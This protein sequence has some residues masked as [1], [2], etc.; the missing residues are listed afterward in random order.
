MDV[1]FILT[2]S[3]V[4]SILFLLKRKSRK[5]SPSVNSMKAI[6]SPEMTY[7]APNVSPRRPGVSLSTSKKPVVLNSK[8]AAAMIPPN[9][10]SPKTLLGFG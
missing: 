9:T 3:L 1:P 6:P 4:S 5:L 7:K 10:R 8:T 2:P